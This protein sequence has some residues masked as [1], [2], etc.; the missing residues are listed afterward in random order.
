MVLVQCSIGKVV[1]HPI[2]SLGL[3]FKVSC[4]SFSLS[5]CIALLSKPAEIWSIVYLSTLL[6]EWSKIL[7]LRRMLRHLQ[8]S[9]WFSGSFRRKGGAV[10]QAAFRA[11][12]EEVLNAEQRWV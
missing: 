7:L 11:C 12:K 10:G 1:N 9:K 4:W 3:I 6:V 8:E 2:A 5:S